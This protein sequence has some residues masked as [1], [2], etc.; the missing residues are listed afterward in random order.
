[1][2]TPPAMPES[3]ASLLR[4]ILKR[5]M[6][7]AGGIA[8]IAA[9]MNLA[10]VIFIIYVFDTVVP[11]NSLTALGYASLAVFAVYCVQ[12]ALRSLAQHISER[13]GTGLLDSLEGRFI[14]TQLRSGAHGEESADEEAADLRN[15]YALSRVFRSKGF[16]SA[17]EAVCALGFLG[18]LFAINLYLGLFG[19]C[20]VLAL[21]LLAWLE[22]RRKRLSPVSDVPTSGSNLLGR[23]RGDMPSSA[24]VDATGYSEMVAQRRVLERKA[25]SAVLA[26]EGLLRTAGAILR[27][28][29][30]SGILAVGALLVILDQIEIGELLASGL[31]MMRIFSPT[32]S[33]LEN[34]GT[35]ASGWKSY[36]KLNA[37][38]LLSNLPENPA[39]GPHILAVEIPRDPQRRPG[40]AVS[41]TL[42][43]GEVAQIT[44]PTGSGKSRILA[45]IAGEHLPRGANVRWDDTP[46]APAMRA[47]RTPLC[48]Y[49]PQDMAFV[50]GT[51][52]ETVRRF[53]Q[54]IDRER[55][56]EICRS[57]GCIRTSWRS[58]TN[59]ARLFPP[60]G[61]G[62][63]FQ[64][65]RRIALARALTTGAP[66][67]VLDDPL[68]GLGEQYRQGV[69]AGIHAASGRGALVVIA[70]ETPIEGLPPGPRIALPKVTGADRE[71]TKS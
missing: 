15:L 11:A 14:A 2:T 17:I 42:R 44:G 59:T 49:A 4:A 8:L 29:T 22:A 34:I 41:I 55:V 24:A 33:F 21:I 51:I 61:R 57:L 9:M 13:A 46:I 7:L 43:D 31:L 67:L 35:L 58:N 71:A 5:P 30:H 63:P 32:N 69:L 48:G 40:V 20:C 38:G 16:L 39:P 66:L 12:A 50:A 27:N 68:L 65:L 10:G 37:F 3:V 54:A 47:S 45:T 60:G 6:L 36:Q 28:V 18:I 19:L 52:M 26:G 56:F 1:M 70:S 64:L 25:Q 53:D 23:R 62:L